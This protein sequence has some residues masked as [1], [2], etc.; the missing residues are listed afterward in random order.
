M[1]ADSNEVLWQK[2]CEERTVFIEK[3]FGPLQEDILKIGHMTGV[4]PGGGLYKLKAIELGK[5]KWLYTTFGLS[6][7]DMPTTVTVSDLN[8]ESENDRVSGSGNTLSKKENVPSYPGRPGYGYEIM[9]VA[10]ESSDWPLWFL[11]WAVNAEILNDADLLGRVEKY[12]GLTIEDIAVGDGQYIN[13]F[14]SLANSPLPKSIQLTNGEARIL[15]ATVI[16]DDEMAWSMS[17]GRQALN[18]ALSTANVGQFSSL[19]RASIF[20]SEPLDYSTIDSIEKAKSFHE[21]GLLRKTYLFPLEFGGKDI[22]VNIIYLPRHAA[23][24]KKAVEEQVMQLAQQGKIE[25]YS[26]KPV[27]KGE[28]FIAT[29]IEIEASGPDGLKQTIDIW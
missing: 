24:K 18:E 27:Y 1:A 9:I 16:T 22:E 15:V 11:Q 19:D 12:D 7:P 3:T 20:Y 10:N 29:T 2:I 17:N 13:V 8:V 14:I 4:W 28:S 6:N 26:A 23:N 25:N 21:K 5:D